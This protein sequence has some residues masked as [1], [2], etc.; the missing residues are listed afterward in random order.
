[1]YVFGTMSETAV[2]RYFTHKSYTT[3]KVREKILLIFAFLTGQGATLS[4]VAVHRTHH[5]FEDSVRDP[6]SPHHN[7]VWKLFLGLFPKQYYSPSLV[8]D[9]LRSSNSKYLIF[10]N[11]YYWIMWTLLWIISYSV[12]PLLFFFIVSGSATW[13]LTT[14]TVNVFAHSR[15]GSKTDENAVGINSSW[16]NLLSGA[17][18]HNNH[19]S[20]PGN[21][22][23]RVTNEID[24]Y[25]WIIEKFLK[26]KVV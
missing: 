8:A 5:A 14:Q 12:N 17:G 1:M 11:K 20:N 10:E 23:Y 15:H 13:Y 16:I 18:H 25:S 3:D 7:S 2:H 24:I 19:H 22:T 4:W 6:H 9:L 21:Y 26:T